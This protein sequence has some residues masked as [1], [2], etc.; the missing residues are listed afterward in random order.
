MKCRKVKKRLVD[1]IEDELKALEKKA[2]DDHLEACHKCSAELNGLR[3]TIGLTKRV[4]VPLLSERFWINFLPNVREKIEEREQRK[5]LFSF[6]LVPAFVVSLSILFI[7]S[8][9]YFR[10]REPNIE[11]VEFIESVII[12][13]LV[14]EE[15][16][17]DAI[18]MEIL[19]EE[20]EIEN[21]DI[22]ILIDE[23]EEEERTAF[24]KRLEKMLKRG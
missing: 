10:N 5:Q 16:E 21:K 23:M 13:N 22:S 7:I 4:K 9:F 11:T 2:I 6:K 12:E 8:I 19:L 24:C 1:Y 18:E 14:N 15:I 17:K 20:R 3:E